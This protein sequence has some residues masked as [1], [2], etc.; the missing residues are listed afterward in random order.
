MPTGSRESGPARR[1]RQQLGQDGLTHFKALIGGPPSGWRLADASFTSSEVLFSLVRGQ[2]RLVFS[3]T[4]RPGRAGGA[5]GLSRRDAPQAPTR[6][7]RALHKAL[8]AGLAAASFA[9]LIARLR[10]D[11]LLYSDPDGS[12]VPSRL[13]GFFQLVDHAPDFWKFCYPQGGFLDDEVRFGSRIAFVSHG[14]LECQLNNPR[15]SLPALRYFADAHRAGRQ[16]GS[17]V[18]VDTSLS[19]AD[20]LAGRTQEILGRTLERVAREERPAFIHLRTTCLPELL[21]DNPTPFIRRIESRLGVPIFWTAKTRPSAPAI[22]SWVERLLGRV[23]FAARRDP[24]AVILA[25]I[26]SARAGAEAAALCAELGLRVVAELLPDLDLRRAP[27]LGAAGAVVWLDPAGWERISDGPFLS[28]G[29]KVVRTHPPFGLAGTQAW[30]ERIASVLGLRGGAC[31]RVRQARAAEFAELQRACRRRTVGLAGDPDDLE[32][33]CSGGRAFGFSPAALLAELGFGVRCLVYSAGTGGAAAALRRSR[34]AAGGGSI[35]FVPF[36]S[37][38]A[39]DREL[40]RGLDL[41]FSHFSHDPR[42]AAHGLLG[43][44]EK[45][46]EPGLGGLLRSGGR[47]LDRCA[48]RPFP[49]HRARLSPWRQ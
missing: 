13:E 37:R 19:E 5:V 40:G 31:S 25:G 4:P 8:G 27:E 23:R 6:R 18:F 38:A 41:V 12:R 7:E 1:P 46:F 22:E 30:L 42:L 33:L 49:R 21:G 26:P 32:L 36:A 2:A 39:L 17:C 44:N 28:R 15:T 29:L 11:S 14:T 35:E 45:I 10:R 3:L 48:G 34:M 20:V 16:D 47:L 24:R 9:A 43:F